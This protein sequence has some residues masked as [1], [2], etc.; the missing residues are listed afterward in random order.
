ME[1]HLQI[2]GRI[3]KSRFMIGTG[4]FPSDEVMNKCLVASEAEIITV[5]VR[6]VDFDRP[7]ADLLSALDRKSI[8]ILPNTSGAQNA[9]EA[10]RLASLA[11]GMGLSNWVKLEVTPDPNYL[12]P[13]GEETLKAAKILVQE[14]FVVLPYIGPDPLLAKKL[15]DAGT[16][17][18]MPLASPIGSNKGLRSPDTLRI[19][20][21]QAGIP[22][23]IDA[24][25]GSP[26]DAAL[27]MEMGAD[28]V[29][30]NTAVSAAPDPVRMAE[31][32]RLAVQ[33][34]RLAFLGGLAPQRDTAKAS[35][36]LEWLVK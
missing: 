36:P 18:V 8:S 1:D 23:V 10:V 27:A 19:I 3:L 7:G 14:G 30:I 20:I 13:D 33:A 15:E 16:A 22:V 29:M 26:S 24:G 28:A 2:A 6:R 5:A 25:I 12:W 4:K 35:S 9:Q 21:R 17:A 11:R 34:G 32:F 31:A